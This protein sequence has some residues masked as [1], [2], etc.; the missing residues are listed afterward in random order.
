MIFVFFGVILPLGPL[1]NEYFIVKAEDSGADSQG[2]W[3]RF[4][5]KWSK[6]SIRGSLLSN[7]EF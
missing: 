5:P 6:L 4:Q 3:T 2:Y 7:G 1:E